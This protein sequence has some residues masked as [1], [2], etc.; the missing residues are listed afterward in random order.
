[1]PE[2]TVQN[3]DRYLELI[4]RIAAPYRDPSRCEGLREYSA[5]SYRVTSY[6][7]AM[8][9]FLY[10][11][12]GQAENAE[13]ARRC[14]IILCGDS[15]SEFGLHAAGLAYQFVKK[16]SA[17][18]DADHDRI[19][20]N[21]I[22][23][24]LSSRAKILSAA[25]DTR[26]QNHATFGMAGSERIAS[27]FPDREESGLLR[28]YAE[29]IW[30]EC[31]AAREN[32]EVTALYEPF[33]QTSLMVVASLRNLEDQYFSDPIIKAAIERRSAISGYLSACLRAIC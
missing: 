8:E 4:E 22:E 7:A 27:L 28:S 26:I 25:P 30:N 14:L 21:L 32:G 15:L 23:S 18:S 1:M 2:C 29:Q 12:R 3:K 20:E 9:G 31:W 19:Q 13:R 10:R 5:I 17:L 6:L 11:R 33:T 24:A 16:S